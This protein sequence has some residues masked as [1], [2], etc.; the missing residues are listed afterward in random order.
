MMRR[1]WPL[2]ALLA[3]AG[4]TIHL[5]LSERTYYTEPAHW[6]SSQSSDADAQ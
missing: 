4:C 3:L 2:A 6:P 5:H 1:L